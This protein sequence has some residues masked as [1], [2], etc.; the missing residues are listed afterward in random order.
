MTTT[1]LVTGCLKT[2]LIV[3]AE[4]VAPGRAAVLERRAARRLRVPAVAA[5]RVLLAARG[6]VCA[7]ASEP[8][9]D[10]RGRTVGTAG[11]ERRAAVRTGASALRIALLLEVG[12]LLGDIAGTRPAVAAAP[13]ATAAPAAWAAAAACCAAAIAAFAGAADLA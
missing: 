12:T 6:A 13:P 9:A 7:G 11:A 4:E 1:A 2:T 3:G 8:P 10:V 5:G